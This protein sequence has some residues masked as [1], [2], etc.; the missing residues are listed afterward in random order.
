MEMNDKPLLLNAFVSMA[1]RCE[2]DSKIIVRRPEEL[3]QL[4]LMKVVWVGSQTR[5]WENASESMR[6]LHQGVPSITILRRQKPT[7]GWWAFS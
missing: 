6:V 2:G 7:V 1:I 3:K 5:L 4:V